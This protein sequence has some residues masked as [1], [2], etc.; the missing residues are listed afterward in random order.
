MATVLFVS[1]MAVGAQADVLSD[2]KAR[3]E[4]VVGTEF[5]YAPFEFLDGDKPVGF[6]VDLITL[7]AKDMGLKVKWIDLPWASVLPALEAKKFDMVV[8]GTTINKARMERYYFTLPIGDAT[9][10]LVK[11]AGD[12]SITKPEDI[13]GKPVGGTKG[14]SQL[15]TLEEFSATLKPP[16]D[17]KIYIGSTNAYADVLA[18]RTVAASGSL[19]NLTYLA[20]TRPEFEVVKPAFGQPSYQAWPLRKEPESESLLAA[21]N[22]GIAK[23]NKNG[24]MKELQIKWFGAEMPLPYDKVPEP[25]Y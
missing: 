17:I 21:I 8:A 10:A 12:T 20:K 15:K 2:A 18:G 13:A 14:S 9:V 4:L 16:A 24:K 5:Q 22:E 3:G 25:N 1:A 7:I 23:Y 19:P 11:R 6:D